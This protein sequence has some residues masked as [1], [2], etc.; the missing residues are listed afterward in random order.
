MAREAITHLEE[1]V[2]FMKDP[3]RFPNGSYVVMGGPFEFTDGTGQVD[4]CQPE[5]ISI[6]FFGDLDLSALALDVAGL[7]GFQRWADPTAQQAIISGFLEEYMRIVVQYQVDYVWVLE[8]FCGH[9]YVA[10]GR[11]PDITNP[12]YRPDDPTLWFDVS[13]THPNDA[14]HAALFR[15]FR[16]VIAE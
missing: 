10:A 12:C 6:P 13:C 15:L 16:D 7:V 4:S 1:A 11:D 3:D 14:G 2:R 9:G 5:S 8:H